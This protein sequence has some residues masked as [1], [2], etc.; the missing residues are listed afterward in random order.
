MLLSLNVKNPNVKSNAQIKDAKCSI[1]QNVLLSANN[2]IALPIAKHPNQNAN[3]CVKN[4]N[5][6]GNVI[7]QT[8]QN[9]S[10]SLC[11]RTPT[12]FLKL[13]VALAQWD[14]QEFLTLCH[15][16]KSKNKIKNAANAQK[17]RISLY[18]QIL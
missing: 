9:P 2:P 16:S 8:A 12:V 1:A 7:N 14:K 10:A 6:I 11:A 3:Q 17:I 5:V 4:L 15:S 18:E 13:N